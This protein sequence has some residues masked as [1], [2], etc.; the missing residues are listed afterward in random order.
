MVNKIEKFLA[1]LSKSQRNKLAEIVENL[2]K[3]WKVAGDVKPLV[4][5][6]ELFR[7]RTGKFRIVFKI[8]DGEVLIL[9]IATRNEKTYR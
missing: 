1:K 3:N 4:G 2:R 9:K 8:M 5:K 7:L 6:K